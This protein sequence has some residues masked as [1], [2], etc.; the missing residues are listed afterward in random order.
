MC[1]PRVQTNMSLL[2]EQNV[3]EINLLSIFNLLFQCPLKARFFNFL[4]YYLTGNIMKGKKS[5]ID[6]VPFRYVGTVTAL[7]TVVQ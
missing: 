1:L 2:T 6:S 3:G 5:Y 7:N 4:I